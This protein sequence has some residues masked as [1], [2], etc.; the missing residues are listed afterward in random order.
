ML[1]IYN[2]LK[3]LPPS[4]LKFQVPIVCTKSSVLVDL[5][6]MLARSG[7]VKVV[8]ISQLDGDLGFH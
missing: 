3:L 7:H 4:C 5:A 8:A 1:S 2:Q 6:R